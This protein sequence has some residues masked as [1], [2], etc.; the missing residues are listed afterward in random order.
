MLDERFRALKQTRPPDLWPE[1]EGREPRPPRREIP[2]GRLGTAALALVVAAAGFAFAYQAFRVDRVAP[3]NVEPSPSV[4]PPPPLTGEPKITAEIP[5]PKDS[6][7][8][9]VAVGAGSVWVV[10]SGPE[11]GTTR[12]LRIDP[13]TNEVVA[14]IPVTDAGSASLVATGGAIW[15]GSPEGIERVDPA[16]N[17]IVARIEV[18][19]GIVSALA[20]DETSVWATAI[21]DRSDGGFQNTA[22]LVRVDVATNEVVAE[23]PLGTSAT[24]YGDQVSLGADSVWVLGPRLV[25]MDTEKGG[26]LIRVDPT[27]NEITATIPAGGFSMVVSDDSVWVSGPRDGVNDEYDEPWKWVVVDIAT[28]QVAR[29]VPL[30]DRGLQLVTP[31]ALWSVDYDKNLHVRAT[32]YEPETLEMETRSDPIESY[33]TDAVVDPGTRTI[34][35][36]AV[37]SLV[38]MD[39]A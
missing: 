21:T 1:I 20:A 7:S 6:V 32:R 28:N 19:E 27:T 22:T 9:G 5:F 37:E 35:V 11:A 10:I 39:I 4:E 8:G 26:D 12:M 38:R 36:S 13:S 18:P 14:E 25:G 31:D 3:G 2:W 17:T 23:I 24:G 16:T 34:W 33:F 15:L 29:E 30:D